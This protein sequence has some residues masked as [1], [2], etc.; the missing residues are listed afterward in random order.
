MGLFSK[1]KGVAGQVV[2]VKVNKWINWN[3]IK[4]TFSKTTDT[5]KDLVRTHHVGEPETFEEATK[6]LGLTEQDLKTKI[7]N[8]S[9]LFL[10][11]VFIATII[12]SYSVFITIKNKNLP[13][14]LLGLAVTSL[15]LVNAF[16]YHFWCFQIKSRK[17]GCSF[18]EWLHDEINDDKNH[19][20]DKNE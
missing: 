2:N 13:G 11:Y 6:R 3:G 9:K 1:A 14:F 5:A 7:Q 20:D 10:I 12:F 19:D 16:R 15:S 17:L 18:K 8:F 4:D